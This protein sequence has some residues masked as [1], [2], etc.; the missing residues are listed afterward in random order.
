MLSI[1]FG[2]MPN[3]IYN[4]SA[5]FD[6]QY[7]DSWLED[8]FAAEVIK[9]IEKGTILS[10]QAIDTKALGVIPVTKIAGG[11]KRLLLIKNRPELVFN[12]S[13]CGNNCAAFLLQ[14]GKEQ[15][16]TINLHHIMDFGKRRFEI[17]VL[18]NNVIVHNMAELAENSVLFI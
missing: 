1:Y 18:N 11:T 7:L 9:K 16:V 15:D 6:N 5:F 12:A 8:E 4:T 3:A 17:R 2:E 10:P 13:T 14:I